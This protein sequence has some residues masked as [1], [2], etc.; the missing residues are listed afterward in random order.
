MTNLRSLMEVWEHPFSGKD[1]HDDDRSSEYKN[2]YIS[3]TSSAT[4][5]IN[6]KSTELT[7]HYHQKPLDHHHW[8]ELNLYTWGSSYINKSLIHPETASNDSRGKVEKLDGAMKSIGPSTPH[9]MHVYSGI[10]FD[11]HQNITAENGQH[12]LHLPAFTST[13]IDPIV[14]K[15]FSRGN[16]VKIHVPKGSHGFYAPGL[17]GKPNSEHEFIIPRGAKLHIHPEPTDDVEGGSYKIWH[18][19]LV[20]DGVAPTRHANEVNEMWE[21]PFSGKDMIDDQRI[22]GHL[23]AAYGT[24]ETARKHSFMLVHRYQ[25]RADDPSVHQEHHRGALRS[26]ASGSY[27][28]NNALI[29]HHELGTPMPLAHEEKSTNISEAIKNIGPH[30]DHDMHVYSGIGFDPA[31]M[32]RDQTTGNYHI[33]LPA[34]TSTSVSPGVAQDFAKPSKQDTS[35]P[36]SIP[37]YHYNLVKIHV[38]EGSHGVPLGVHNAGISDEHEFLLHKDAKIH[39]HPE[40]TIHSNPDSHAIYKIWHAKLVHDGV[41]PTR[42]M[43]EDA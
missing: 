16:I 43:N 2:G 31:S 39:V 29:K 17:E 41:A 7:N 6:A 23:H 30:L 11:P 22:Y 38:P 32:P 8:N 27:G 42:H 35:D 12:H 4:D 26:Y 9:D 3:G 21:H 1:Y 33:H 18:A 14:A 34:F 24:N 37:A 5:N 28:V 15:V 20:H 10:K 36:A 40:P 25:K 19:K 13:T